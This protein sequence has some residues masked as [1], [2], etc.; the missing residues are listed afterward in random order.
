[1]RTKQKKIIYENIQKVRQMKKRRKKMVESK[2]EQLKFLGISEW[3][4]NLSEILNQKQ[5]EDKEEK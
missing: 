3:M 1:M 5:G 2:K 4:I